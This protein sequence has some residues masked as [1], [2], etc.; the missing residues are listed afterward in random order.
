MVIA[1]GQGTKTIQVMDVGGH[2][3]IS[4]LTSTD[5]NAVPHGCGL[6]LTILDLL[7]WV[8]I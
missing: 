4:L 7:F 6:C 3:P 8:S 1:Q 2:I 5:L